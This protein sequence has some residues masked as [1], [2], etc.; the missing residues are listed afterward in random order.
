MDASP[1]GSQETTMSLKSKITSSLLSITVAAIAVA[2]T[3]E[4]SAAKK[5]T[6]GQV[7]AIAG[8]GGFVLGATIAGANRGPYYHGGPYHAH[9]T[10]WQRHV[11]RCYD[12][13]Q[14]YDHRTDTYVGFDGQYHYCRL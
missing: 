10:P 6:N 12:H 5:L 2:G 3:I 13:Y 7:A 8:I 4:P 11:D 14:S 1:T 9:R